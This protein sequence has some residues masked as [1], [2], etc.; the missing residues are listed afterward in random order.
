MELLL[1]HPQRCH[2]FVDGYPR[3]HC[4]LAFTFVFPSTNGSIDTRARAVVIEFT[5]ES[6]SPA[7]T[8]PRFSTGLS[9]E[10][11]LTSYTRLYCRLRHSRCASIKRDKF[12]LFSS[13][14]SH[15]SVCRAHLPSNFGNV[16]ISHRRIRSVHESKSD[17]ADSIPSYV[18]L[19]MEQQGSG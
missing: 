16:P 18:Q 7:W 14:S 11:P 12:C 17:Y 13:L 4:L 9:S 19:W 8:S 6:G 15:T 10:S 5:T 1:A 3:L 2:R